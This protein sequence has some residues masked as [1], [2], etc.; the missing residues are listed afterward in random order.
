MP[1]RTP[2]PYR[3]RQEV[4]MRGTGYREIEA[5]QPPR[6]HGLQ[7]FALTP[8]PIPG[9]AVGDGPEMDGESGCKTDCHNVSGGIIGTTPK[10]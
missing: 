4:V 6:G 7:H 3:D 1:P 5:V 2:L 10:A 9:A 8:S